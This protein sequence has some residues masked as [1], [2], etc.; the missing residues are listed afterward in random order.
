MGT[1]STFYSEYSEYFRTRVTLGTLSTQSTHLFRQ[2]HS[3][4]VP[5]VRPDAFVPRHETC[6][7]Q[8]TQVQKQSLSRADVRTQHYL[9]PR[10]TH[11][12]RRHDGAASLRVKEVIQL[13]AL[14]LEDTRR[15]RD[16]G[17]GVRHLLIIACRGY[18]G[19]LR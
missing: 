19:R 4:D 7:T 2:M 1:L 3:I 6:V 10:E 12:P 9:A 8:V 5:L 14:A 16:P 17:D 11:A 13:L 18:R 15:D